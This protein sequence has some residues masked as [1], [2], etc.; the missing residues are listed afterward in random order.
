MPQK[1]GH[2]KNYR[3]DLS[4]KKEKCWKEY[5]SPVWTLRQEYGDKS[6]IKKVIK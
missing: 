3:N 4:I 1:Y 6:I 2:L 5:M